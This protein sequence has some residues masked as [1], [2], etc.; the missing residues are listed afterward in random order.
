MNL[1]G[2]KVGSKILNVLMIIKLSMLAL[3]IIA[4][5]FVQGKDANQVFIAPPQTTADMFKAFALCFV[6][7]FFTYSGYQQAMNFGGDAINPKKTIPQSINIG[8][9]IVLSVYLLVNY[10]YYKVLGFGGLQN[11]TTLA[12]D[13]TGLMFGNM[14]SKLVSVIMFFSVMA[15]VNVS[16]MANPR[17]YYAMA[18]DGVLPIIFKKINPKTQVQQFGLTFYT[19]LIIITL[20][21][22]S[23]FGEILNYVIFFDSISLITAAAA[24]FI[25]RKKIVSAI[26]EQSVYKMKGYPIIPALYIIAFIGVIVVLLITKTDSFLWGGVLFIGGLPLYYLI[27]LALK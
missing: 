13:I 24:I 10:S 6:P 23:S 15:Y 2:I 27:R 20:F 11:S 19:L 17:V 21:F 9:I 16:L 14:A 22:I 5:F 12:S 3:L 7:V 18:E 4:M 8:I 26:E 1:L 25:L